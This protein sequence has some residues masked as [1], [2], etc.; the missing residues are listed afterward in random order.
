MKRDQNPQGAIQIGS[1][2]KTETLTS[3]A[4]AFAEPTTRLNAKRIRGLSH[5]S[6]Y[7]KRTA[8]INYIKRIYPS[9]S[10]AS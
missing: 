8:V 1:A 3:H 10:A 6:N 7:F 9:S 4:S 2:N 5:K